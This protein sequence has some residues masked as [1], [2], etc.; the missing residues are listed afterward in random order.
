MKNNKVKYLVLGL[1]LL[2]LMGLPVLITLNQR[3]QDTRTRATASTTLYFTPSA[4]ASSPLVID[5][6]QQ[7][8]FDLWVN[9][10]SNL[11]STIKV[12]L[13]YDPTKLQVTPTSFASNLSAFPVTLEGPIYTNGHVAASISIGSDFTKAIQVPTRVATFKFTAI[14]YTNGTPTTISFGP[15]TM[16]L[17]VGQTDS[18]SENV[19]ATVEPAHIEIPSPPTPTPTPPSA[20]ALTVLAALH[21]IGS[22]GDNTNPT[23]ARLSNKSPLHLERLGTVFVYNAQN[24]LVSTGAGNLTYD[25]DKG[26]F[27]GKIN[28][29]DIIAQGSYT[30]R[31]QV[32]THLR[33][34]V[35]GI[36]NLTPLQN[37]LLPL[38]EMIAGDINSDNVLNILDYNFIMGCYSDL[39]PAKDCNETNKMNSDL[40]DDGYVNQVDYNLF[41]REISTQGGN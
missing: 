12:D 24:Q 21:G 22:S 5:L 23:D 4:S 18:S 37:N 40:N 27:T 34:L 11:P 31:V 10:G 19:L 3:N 6:N 41:L 1:F 17:S 36:Q 9:P 16:V 13:T 20:T 30:I 7:A 14:G 2:M 29:D 15:N 28:I 8:S 38:I 26:Y 33:R 32:P 25:P 39:L 35:P